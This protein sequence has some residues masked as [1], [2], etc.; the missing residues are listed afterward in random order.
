MARTA[1]QWLESLIGQLHIQVAGLVAENE[2]LKEEVAKLKAEA[3][4]G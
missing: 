1:Q 2:A 4:K 3:L